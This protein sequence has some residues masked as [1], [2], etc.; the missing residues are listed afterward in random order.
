[1]KSGQC[2]HIV[3]LYTHSCFIAAGFNLSLAHCKISPNLTL[4]SYKTASKQFTMTMSHRSDSPISVCC[5]I[6][7]R[8]K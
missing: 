2:G 7:E 3:C 8:E 1:M 6:R 4:Y 5:V